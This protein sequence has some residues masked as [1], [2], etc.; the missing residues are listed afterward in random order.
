[1]AAPDVANLS[2]EARSDAVAQFLRDARALLSAA[3]YP[4]A[5]QP[6]A[7]NK[8]LVIAI[9]ALLYV[10]MMYGRLAAMLV[11]LY[12]ARIRY[13]GLFL[14]YNL[15]FGWIGGFLPATAF[16][17]VAAT[18]DARTLV[19]D[20]NRVSIFCVCTCVHAGELPKQA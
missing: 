2:P 6:E 11:E 4:E 20:C 9:V 5:A 12:P 10:T 19:P 15:G 17:I 13:T 18:G 16:A 7:I 1:M 14:P 3:G 8:P